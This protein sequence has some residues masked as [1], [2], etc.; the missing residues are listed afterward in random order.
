M[1]IDC[2]YTAGVQ[3]SL[4]FSVLCLSLSVTEPNKNHANVKMIEPQIVSPG[5]KKK[6]KK[7][8]CTHQAALHLCGMNLYQGASVSK[9][10]YFSGSIPSSSFFVQKAFTWNYSNLNDSTFISETAI[11]LIIQK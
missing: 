9:R 4:L 5:R 8:R 11:R 2:F 1:C 6:K 10:I 7:N 3:F